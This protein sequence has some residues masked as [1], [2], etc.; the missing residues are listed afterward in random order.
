MKLFNYMN[1]WKKDGEQL[2]C[3]RIFQRLNDGFYAVQNVDTYH[4]ESL[5]QQNDF[6]ENQV[7]ELFL[8]EDIEERGIFEMS[9]E[10]A[11]ES[12]ENSF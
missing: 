12:F 6:F 9:I 7:R 10:K 8:E 3:Y 11:I 2:C 4:L 5:K 1:I